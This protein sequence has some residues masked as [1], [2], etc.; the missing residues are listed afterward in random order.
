MQLGYCHDSSKTLD[1]ADDCSSEISLHFM[2]VEAMCTL[3]LCTADYVIVDEF[4]WNFN[5]Q[6]RV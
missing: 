6:K 3:V 4:F 5:N 1:C 2:S